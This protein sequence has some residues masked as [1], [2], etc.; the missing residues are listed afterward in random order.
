VSPAALRDYRAK[1]DFRVTPEPGDRA[2]PRRA[3]K[4]A[5]EFVVQEHHARRLHWDFRLELDGRLKSWAVPKGPSLE[6]KVKRLAVQVEDHPL[7]YRHF[8]GRIP[9]GQYGAGTV[10]IWDRGHWTPL[11]DPRAGLE[12]GK[13]HFEL[14]GERLHGRWLLVRSGKDGKQWLLFADP[15]TAPKAAAAAPARKKAAKAAPPLGVA[16][17][18]PPALAP[19]LAT[20][21]P[22]LPED[23]H[24]WLYEIKFDG[25]RLL[26][27]RDG[28]RTQL[29]TRNGLDWSARFGA[30]ARRLA[31][32][33]LADGFYDG[34]VVVAG[35][36]GR[37]DFGAL[38]AALEAGGAA[39]RVPFVLHLFDLPFHDGRDL[40]ALPLH[41]RRARLRDVLAALGEVEGLRFSQDFGEAASPQQLHAQACKL[42]LEGLMAKRRDSRYAS[43]RSTDWLK[44]KCQQRQEFVIGGFTAPAGSRSGFGALLLGLREDDGRLRYAG[45]VGSGFAE[46]TLRALHGRLRERVV[47]SSPF[48]AGS[49]PEGK[50]IQWVR[51]DLVAEVSHNGLTASGGR[52]RQGVFIGLR[53]DKPAA[54]VK[55][56]VTLPKLTHPERVIDAS[57]GLTK[58]DLARY[59]A[60]AAPLIAP[61]LARRPTAI[62]RAPAGIGGETFFQKQAGNARIEGLT[63][64]KIDAEHEMFVVSVPEGLLS[65]AQFNVIEFHTAGATADAP[66]RPDRLTFDLDPGEGVEWPALAQAALLTRVLLVELGLVPF[67]KTSGGKG[68]H[69]VTPLRR[70]AATDWPAC[71]AFAKAVA[72]H[73]AHTLP[74]HFVAIAGPKRRVGK[75]FVD[76]LRNQSGATTVA[77]WSARVRP[78]LGVSVPLAWDELDAAGARPHWGVRDAIEA[79]PQGNAPWADY[80]ASRR[81]LGPAARKLAAAARA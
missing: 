14:H 21:T 74:E 38:Q 48:S 32:L 35:P 69:I 36:E 72:E 13:L 15:D 39:A 24:E 50:G 46:A 44:V 70:A 7:A 71:K 78:G 59:Y 11:H 63:E 54:A 27:R 25:Y 57:S 68:L 23:A 18:L 17:P 20:A 81:A 49:K 61:H 6:P 67:L 31:A 58:L 19:M 76:Y 30:F 55:D 66:E 22:A 65:A 43:A 80:A 40:R 53:E 33:P 52:V 64:V 56:E 73:L 47:R 75:V 16:A 79:R 28:K 37:P 29:L 4:Q 2:A 8:E 9:E 45:N 51:P 12:K 3:G 60:Q 5:L 62:V 42:G 41:Q 1:R 10:S 26:L 34:E 77:A